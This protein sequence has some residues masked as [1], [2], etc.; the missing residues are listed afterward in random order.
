[1]ESLNKAVAFNAKNIQN[2]QAATPTSTTITKKKGSAILPF[3]VGIAII[4]LLVAYTFM[5]VMIFGL[6]LPFIS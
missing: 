5:W 3:L 1:M 6:K 4:F 2:S